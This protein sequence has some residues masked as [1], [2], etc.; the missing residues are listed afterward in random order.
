MVLGLSETF[1]SAVEQ[2]I[3]NAE[4]FGGQKGPR[5]D[6]FLQK[7]DALSSDIDYV[8]LVRSGISYKLAGTDNTTLSFGYMESLSY[9]IS[10]LCD[11]HKENLLTSKIALGGSLFGY[12]RFSEMIAKNL[13]PNHTICFNKEL[14]IDQ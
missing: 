1:E 14:P 8:R 4:D 13:K 9:F 11:T 12:K 7:E 5:I 6:Y 10:D 3:E 2:L